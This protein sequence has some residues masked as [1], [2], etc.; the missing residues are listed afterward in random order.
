MSAAPK[1]TVLF[2]A[3]EVAPLIKT[4]GLADV[5][6]ALPAALMHAGVDVRVLLPGYKQVMEAV[7]SKGRLTSFPALGEMPA[8]QLNDAFDKLAVDVT[9][10]L[11]RDPSVIWASR[12]SSY[13]DTGI[14]PV[15][16]A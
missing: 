5:A 4:G 7:K 16:L 3:S 8:S 15:I 11:A 6:G 2:V 12:P 1:L 14:P 9:G 13:R 10:R